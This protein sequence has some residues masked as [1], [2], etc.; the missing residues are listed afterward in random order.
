MQKRKH[1]KT[2][3]CKISRY[4]LSKFYHN[5][6]EL[7]DNRANSIAHELYLDLRCLQIEMFHFWH[8]DF[9]WLVVLGLTAFWGIIS[10][11]MGHLPEV[12]K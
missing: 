8:F 11:I 6:R 9:G 3:G 1:N 7:E 2:Q 5:Y 10:N 12:I 4:I